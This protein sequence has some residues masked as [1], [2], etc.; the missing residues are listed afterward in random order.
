MYIGNGPRH[1]RSDEDGELIGYVEE[2]LNWTQIAAK[3]HRSE[4]SVRGHWYYGNLKRDPRAQGV[5]YMPL[6]G[7]GSAGPR[8]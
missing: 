1:W 8:Q 6:L 4:G 2:G 5:R 7:K 3:M